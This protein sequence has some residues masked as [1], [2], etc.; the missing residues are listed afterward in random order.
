MYSPTALSCVHWGGSEMQK[1]NWGLL[2]LLTMIL[3]LHLGGCTANTPSEE[4]VEVQEQ[5][6]ENTQLT[7][8]EDMGCPETVPDEEDPMVRL[9][10]LTTITTAETCERYEY[11]DDWWKKTEFQVMSYITD[12]EGNKLAAYEASYIGN[13]VMKKKTW[14]DT[15]YDR[16]TVSYENGLC[17]YRKQEGPVSEIGYP[18]TTTVTQYDEYGRIKYDN[19]FFE[20]SNRDYS[21]EFR[22]AYE[23]LDTEEGFVAIA[24]FEGSRYERY[25]DK[26]YRMIEYIFAS[27]GR[28]H[29]RER[30]TYNSAGCLLT[31]EDEESGETVRYEYE[32]IE[33]PLSVAVK[34]PMFKWEYID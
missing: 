33:V 28:L 25:Y 29:S 1:N 8:P 23:V 34:Y 13:T 22:F 18:I 27:S 6:P 3:V 7:I 31:S 9:Y 17:V 30:Y 20:F 15:G 10:Y 26:N 21:A 19:W 5:T 32:S 4:S 11:E 24:D 12:L 14:G 16:E 2:V